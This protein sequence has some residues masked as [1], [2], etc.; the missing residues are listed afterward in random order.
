MSEGGGIISM[1]N[2]GWRGLNLILLVI[3]MA[4]TMNGCNKME[5]KDVA[6][7]TYEATEL[8]IEGI[9]GEISSFLVKN[10]KIY[11]CT[12]EMI[13]GGIDKD[14]VI[15][16]EKLRFY[17]A[18]M[19]GSNPQ[20]IELDLEKNQYLSSITIEEN[21]TFIGM[22]TTDNQTENQTNL[23]LI[24]FDIDGKELLRMNIKESLC[25]E[26]DT[27]TNR[28]FLDNKGDILLFGN[29][30]VYILNQDFKLIND[31]KIEDGWQIAD[32]ALAKNGQV[33]CVENQQNVA[34]ISTRARIFDIEKGKWGDKIKIACNSYSGSDY[35][36]DGIDAD[37]YYK[38]NS[39][40]Y[41]YNIENK[42]SNKLLDYEASYI[43]LEEADSMV[44]ME[45]GKFLGVISGDVTE[46]NTGLV[47]YS[48]VD[49]AS[50]ANRKNIIYGGI[51]I[52]E[53]SKNA[54]M[55]FNKK[56]KDYKIEIKDYIEEKDPIG[57]LNADILAGNAPDILELQSLLV[58][59]Y[60]Q[61][62]LLESL[63][64]YFERDA[65]ISTDDMI[66]SVLEAMKID[67][68]L[69]YVCSSFSLNTV[70]A[71]T[72]D[73]GNKRGWTFSEM[74]AL[75]EEKDGD[76]SLFYDTDEMSKLGLLYYFLE[77]GQA[78]YVDWKTGECTFNSQEF[79]DMLQYCNNKG[80]D[81]EKDVSDTEEMELIDSTPSRIRAGEVLLYVDRGLTLK[82]VQVDRQLFDE[83]IT[84]IGYPNESE[85]GS[86]LVPGTPIGISSTS[87]VKDKAWEFVRTFVTKEYQ[88]RNVDLDMLPTRQDCFDMNIQANM[89][90]KTYTDEFGNVVEP[91]NDTWN[92]GS[93]ELHYKPVS[94]EEVNAF[95]DLIDNT[96]KVV[97][98]DDEITDIVFEEAQVYFEEDRSLEE[99]IK[100]IQ[101][102]VETYVNEQK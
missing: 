13:S 96:T 18:N 49:P 50:L 35:V 41:S 27:L 101:K 77:T 14:D 2:L 48:K 23:E 75:L 61:I 67:N 71:R 10:G 37:I 84:Y 3:I 21:N 90:T 9:Q 44:P 57:R 56:N 55:A 64:P 8:V 25:L 40:I 93:V 74:K 102:R 20:Q 63:T 47:V 54:I 94:Q 53:K 46:D 36:M 58:Q 92:W 78:D 30:K 6:D 38:D 16:T 88:G 95:V 65:E 17:C 81:K 22:V 82:Q 31:V 89:T 62:G 26:Q 98:N 68:E 1:K 100:I 24:R 29:S 80:S 33:I 19:D 97:Y 59:K 60:V 39:G 70:A 99:T 32:I 76:V 79:M 85:Q 15:G 91:L 86:Y 28:I 83:D 72:R 51:A 34:E 69:Y 4:T 42:E 11:L 5:Q 52:K 43:T 7:V 45:N 87:D 12:Y 66:D 73:V